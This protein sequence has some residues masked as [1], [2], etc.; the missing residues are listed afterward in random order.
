M[1]EE[2][3]DTKPK[4]IKVIETKVKKNIFLSPWIKK[5]GLAIAEKHSPT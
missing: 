5:R 3:Q 4:A 1:Q 2:R